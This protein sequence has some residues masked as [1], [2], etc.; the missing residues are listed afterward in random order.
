MPTGVWIRSPPQ[1]FSEVVAR[2]PVLYAD[3]EVVGWEQQA[4]ASGDPSA[5][6]PLECLL[7]IDRILQPVEKQAGVWCLRLQFTVDTGSSSH[8]H[9]GVPF[10]VLDHAERRGL[11]K[12]LGSPDNGYTLVGGLQVRDTHGYHTAMSLTVA[13]AGCCCRPKT[14]RASSTRSVTVWRRSP[15]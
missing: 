13:L 4:A 8:P 14:P 11:L 12:V 10:C 1:V 9:N 15:C 2:L 5:R 6:P 3:I 7:L